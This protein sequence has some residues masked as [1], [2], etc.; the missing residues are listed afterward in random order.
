V[1]QVA[2]FRQ[3]TL[4]AFR[5]HAWRCRIVEFSKRAFI[6]SLADL[7]RCRAVELAM[8][9]S[10]PL[11]PI[12]CINFLGSVT[13]EAT[14]RAYDELRGSTRF[15][16]RWVAASSSTNKH[17]KPRPANTGA[18]E[19]MPNRRTGFAPTSLDK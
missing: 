14:L 10:P 8:R 5:A 7:L 2:P 3:R 17:R 12:A 6:A 18:N 1:F 9:A 16:S 13:Y 11:R 4:A 15:F 19:I